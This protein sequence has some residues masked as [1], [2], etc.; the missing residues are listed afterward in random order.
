[1]PMSE[2]ERELTRK[3]QKRKEDF[4]EGAKVLYTLIMV[5]VNLCMH[6]SKR[7]EMHALKRDILLYITHTSMKLTYLKK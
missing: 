3:R 5:V 6:L 4:Q 7:I 1:M 2:E